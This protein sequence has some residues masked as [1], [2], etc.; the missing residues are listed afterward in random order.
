VHGLEGD[1]AGHRPVADDGDDAAVLAVP[2]A[3]RLLQT[4]G[5]ADRGRGVARAHDV[6]L[7][8]VAGAERG[9]AAVLADRAQ[10]VAP[11]GE[12]LVRV[13]LVADVPEHLVARRVQQRVH[14]DGDL[15]RAEVGAEVP[16]DLPHRVDQQLAH[17]LRDLLE[18]VLR[19]P[20]KVLRAVDGVEE[21]GHEGRV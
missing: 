12:D 19:E 11:A 21:A 7:G 6:V 16:A 4:H 17:L 15:A 20:V 13:R 3:H 8:L 14:G 5:V 9:E 1:A 2:V 10:V 18:L